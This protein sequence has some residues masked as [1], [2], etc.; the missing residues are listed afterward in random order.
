MRIAITGSNSNLG[1][2]LIKYYLNKKYEVFCLSGS[3]KPINLKNIKIFFYNNTNPID[4]NFFIQNK[5]SV[6]IICSHDRSDINLRNNLNINSTLQIV[7]A[8]K[9][10]VNKIMYISSIAASDIAQSN[11]GKIKFNIENKINKY[12]TIIHSSMFFE[13]K[14]VSRLINYLL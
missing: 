14:N 5:I 13:N 2:K 12:V 1:K 9:K 11:Y 6:L 4:K 8:A 3:L 7:D 10:S